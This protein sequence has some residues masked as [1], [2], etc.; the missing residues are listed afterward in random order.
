MSGEN[1][2]TQ[3]LAYVEEITA[4]FQKHKVMLQ[5]QH[6]LF[7]DKKEKPQHMIPLITNAIVLNDVIMLI[8]LIEMIIKVLPLEQIEKMTDTIEKIKRDWDDRKNTILW[9]D[10]LKHETP[11]TSQD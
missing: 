1:L 7:E 5:V 3:L 10:R 2:R 11:D 6:S 4:G 8:N 9:L